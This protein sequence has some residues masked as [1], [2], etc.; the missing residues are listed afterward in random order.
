[1]DKVYIELEPDSWH[2]HT[3]ES[4][5]ATRLDNGLYKVENSPFFARG[6]SYEDIVEV[7][8][9]DGVNRFVR[10][11]FPSGASTYRILLETNT[12]QAQFEHFWTPLEAEGCTYEQGDFDY[13]MYSVN[14]PKEAD[15]HRVFACLNEGETQK[16]WDFEEGHCGHITRTH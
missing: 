9:R 14:V 7:T 3:V 1:M 11:V 5:W 15:V 6:I 8:Q 16:A 13:I 12:T 4:M 2:G 10:T